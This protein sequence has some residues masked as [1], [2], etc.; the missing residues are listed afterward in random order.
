MKRSGS[1]L[2]YNIVKIMVETLGIGIGVGY[3]EAHSFASLMQEYKDDG[4][5]LI[6]K[7]HT[8]I[9]EYPMLY[10]HRHALAIFSY[11]DIRDV[12]LSLMRK[13]SK[14]FYKILLNGELPEIIE[15]DYLWSNVDGTRRS[16]YERFVSDL[17]E[18]IIGIAR[19]LNIK[20]DNKLVNQIIQ[21]TNVE[22][23][24]GRVAGFDWQKAVRYSDEITYMPDTLLHSNHFQS[25][26]VAEW[27]IAFSPLQIL[28][29]ELITHNWLER[30][31]YEISHPQT[32]YFLENLGKWVSLFTIQSKNK[33]DQRRL[34]L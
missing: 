31:G 3:V 18:E 4:K 17:E 34:G 7:S 23:Q 13:Y 19:H 21:N 5:F 10:Q 16:R 33:R 6:V 12:T 24:K 25:G 2:Q 8:F 26:K 27:K 32:V 28:A 9:A 11:R 14:P 15:D 1:T 20:I 29:I 22:A 30:N